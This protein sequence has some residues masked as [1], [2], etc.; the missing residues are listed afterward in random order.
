MNTKDGV[1]I[2]GRIIMND[3][4]TSLGEELKA[5]APPPNLVSYKVKII[6]D[7]R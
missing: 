4:C 2:K 1:I 6:I 7:K 5:K 3:Y